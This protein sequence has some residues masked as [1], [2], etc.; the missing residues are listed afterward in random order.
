MKLTPVLL[1]NFVTLIF[2]ITIHEA[3][4]ALIADLCGDPTAKE[5]G[6]VTLNPIPHIDLL[7]TIIIP[8]GIMIFNPQ[9]SLI[10][11]G[12]PCPVNPFNYK[13][14]ERDDILVSI[15]G[16]GSNFI[17]VI[18]CVIIFKIFIMTG[19]HLQGAFALLNSLIGINIILFVFN[20]IPIPP[21]DGSHIIRYFMSEPIK[22]GFD[23]LDRWGFFI[24]ILFVNT[25]LFGQFYRIFAQPIHYLIKFIF[26]L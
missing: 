16:P 11:W 26:M 19:V 20:L 15:A 4:H 24:L 25:P 5:L 7:G 12:K 2:S 3:S 21:L 10:G 6:R 1:I 9:V 18:L 23:K 17:A 14:A 13:H 8:L 22:E